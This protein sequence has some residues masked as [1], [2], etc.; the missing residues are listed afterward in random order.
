MHLQ[1]HGTV[2][3]EVTLSRMER[4]SCIDRLTGSAVQSRGGGGNGS[5][6]TLSTY[7]GMASA[8]I[9]Q[10]AQSKAWGDP[11]GAVIT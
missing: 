3:V 1:H 2:I 10:D 9:R 11:A 6:Q 4:E 7:T 5:F 8:Q